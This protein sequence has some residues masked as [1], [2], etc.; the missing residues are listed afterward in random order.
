MSTTRPVSFRLDT[1]SARALDELKRTTGCDQSGAIR[2]A[3]LEAAG[4]GRRAA[5]AAEAAELA[6]DPVDRAE[7][8]AVAALM[9][10]LR[11]PG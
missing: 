6:A 8:A 1:E 11:A 7:V 4:R 2:L 10:S 3:L 5:L 9:E